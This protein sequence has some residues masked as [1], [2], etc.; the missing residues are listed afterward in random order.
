VPSQYNQRAGRSLE[1]LAA[2]SDGLFAIAMTLLVLE[3]HLP[4]VAEVHSEAELWAA[5]GTFSPQVG[6]WVMSFLTLGIF[7][8]GQQTQL[9]HLRESD[10]D[11]TWLHI[12]FLFLISMIPLTTR[13]LLSFDGYRL[14]M[15]IYWL[16]LLLMGVVLWFAWSHAV[17][18]GLIAEEAPPQIVIVYRRRIIIAQAFYAV[19]ALLALLD[20]RLSIAFIVAVQLCYA[21]AVERFFRRGA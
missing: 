14:A 8:I 17:R 7:W 5:L 20:V 15:M 3:L 16:N 9:G 1:R 10:R 6:V 19:G 4:E 2:L 18:A 12:G 21:V 13:L 11:L